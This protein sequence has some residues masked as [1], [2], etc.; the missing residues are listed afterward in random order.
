MRADQ[1]THPCAQQEFRDWSRRG[2]S[3]LGMR[4]QR[5][6]VRASPR[7]RPRHGFQRGANDRQVAEH[8]RG[9]DVHARA[10][11]DEIERDVAP[12]HM[13]GGPEPRLPVAVAPIPGCVDQRRMLSKQLPHAI[14][15]AM[16]LADELVDESRRQAVSCLP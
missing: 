13:R 4:E 15:I 5:N 9:E 8:G 7:P 10:V 1:G 16:R 3:R 12:P 11:F 14:E 6:S 2:A